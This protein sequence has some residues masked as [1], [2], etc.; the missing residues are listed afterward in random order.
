MCVPTLLCVLWQ[1]PA[2]IFPSWTRDKFS[3]RDKAHQESVKQVQVLHFFSPNIPQILI[4]SLF[5]SWWQNWVSESPSVRPRPLRNKPSV[6]SS[7]TLSF[8]CPPTKDRYKVPALVSYVKERPLHSTILSI[9]IYI[10]RCILPRI[11]IDAFKIVW[12]DVLSMSKLSA[13]YQLKCDEAP[14]PV[15]S[16]TS[17]L[18]TE[19][20]FAKM[21]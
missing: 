15:L 6:Y 8:N 3:P 7:H 20:R 4:K 5:V 10:Y 14:H 16:I 12:S 17:S 9:T 18:L 2:K 19:R 21:L 11:T 1:V 13:S